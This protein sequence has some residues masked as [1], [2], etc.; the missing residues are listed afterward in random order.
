LAANNPYMMAFV[1][2]RM[3]P[4]WDG[5]ETTSKLWEHD[6]QLQVVICTAYSDYAW[7]E[8]IRKLGYSDRLVIL[9]K[10]FDPIE[11][12]QLA[13]ALTEKWRL[14]QRAQ[15]RLDNLE[16]LVQDRTAELQQ[17]NVR[18]R[19]ESERA[20]QLASAALA[21]SRAK[22]EFLATMSHEIRTPMNGIIGMTDLLLETE[23]TAEQR[24]Y[25]QTVNR[26]PTP[27]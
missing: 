19:T 23:L 9:K 2:V 21:G 6:P 16:R 8:L 14:S 20:N 1:D 15:S 25:A 12:F 10:P 7:E 3:P 27:S 13:N 24:S 22:S 26:A 11:V 4:G 18:L 5:V 17:A